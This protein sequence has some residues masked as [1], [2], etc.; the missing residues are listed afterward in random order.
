MSLVVST[1]ALSYLGAVLGAFH[2]IIV[3]EVGLL[4]RI[5]VQLGLGWQIWTGFDSRYAAMYHLSYDWLLHA[6]Q[7][8]DNLYDELGALIGYD[9]SA[10]QDDH[11]SIFD[12]HYEAAAYDWE[13]WMSDVF[14]SAT[15]W[16]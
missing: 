6:G 12:F 2:Y 7:S 13:T 1:E 11:L 3:G 8:L 5:S 10:W 15:E 16:K 14:D 4:N 9:W